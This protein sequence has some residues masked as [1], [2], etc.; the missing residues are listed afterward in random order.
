VA[1]LAPH[2]Q[3]QS[4]EIGR[5][6]AL[7]ARVDGV[8]ELAQHLGSASVSAWRRDLLRD[9]R[10]RVGPDAERGFKIEGTAG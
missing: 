4:R 5:L 8:E 10:L 3:E 1:P 9:E 2:G 6:V 7:A